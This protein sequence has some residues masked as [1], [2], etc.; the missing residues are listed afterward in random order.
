MIGRWLVRAVALASIAVCIAVAIADAARGYPSGGVY[1]LYGAVAVVFIGVGWL[2]AERKASN[3]VGPLLLAFG[4]LFAWYL[5]ADLYLHLSDD[6]AGADLV[7]LAV[8][9]LDAP[10]FILIALI[11]ILFPD[12]QVPSRRWRWVVPLGGIGIALTV[13]GYGLSVDP[14]PL[15]PDR[16][17]P[18]G[19]GGFPGAGLVYLSYMIMA[20]LL[21]AAAAGLIVRSRRGGT[22]ERTQIKWVVAAALVLLVT[23]LVNVATFRADAPNTVANTLATAG[24]ALV[25]ISMGIAILRY[26]LYDIDRIISRSVGYAV[27][28]GIL[29]V[30]FGGAVVLLSTILAQLAQGQTI[31]VAASTLAVFALF[32]PVRR[33]VQRI[34]DRRFDRARYDSEHIATAFSVRLRHEVDM[35]TVTGDLARTVTTSVAPAS[36]SI[37]L[38]S[39]AAGR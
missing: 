35:E 31:A 29:A 13:V 24:I 20:I 38:R 15:F 17:S 16:H 1:V 8:S 2:I 39:R 22:V 37:W 21:V 28:T 32:Q 33:R 26:R 3:A 25:P 12:G 14:F 18:I 34:V 23:E 36:L 9:M 11:L 27:V 10:M 19:I 6:P 7:A 30:V 4:A 5:P